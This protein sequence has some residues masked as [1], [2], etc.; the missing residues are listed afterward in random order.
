MRRRL[1]VMS[2][3]K[4]LWTRRPIRGVPSGCNAIVREVLRSPGSPIE[5]PVCALMEAS[6][7]CDFGRVR[8]YTDD[9]AAAASRALGAR[10]FTFGS[11]IIFGAGRYAPESR[12]GLW[13]LAHELAHVVQQAGEAPAVPLGLGDPDDPL[14]RAADQA[15]DLAAA[16]RA[17]PPGLARAVAPAGIIWCHDDEDCPGR[18]ISAA[19]RSIWLPANEAIEIAYKEDPRI[20]GHADAIL[21]GSQFENRDIQLPK[22]AP[23]KR[24]GNK[25][26]SRLRGISNQRRPDIIDFSGRVFYEI[27]S[28]NDPGRGTVQLESYYRLSEEIRR[29]YAD[30]DEPPWK[31]EYATWYPP[32]VLPFP[33]DPLNKIVCTKATDHNRWPGRILYD[34]RELD[35][36]EKRRRRLRNACDYSIADFDPEFVEL[37]PAIRAELPRKV[38]SYDPAHPE[39]VI[40]APREFYWARYRQRNQKW[41]DFIRVSPSYNMPGGREFQGMQ[42]INWTILTFVAAVSAGVYTVWIVAASPA[43]ASAISSAAG[44]GAAGAGAAGAGAAGAGAAAEAE[45]VSLAAYRALT[46]SPVARTL[47]KAAGVLMVVGAVQNAR[48]ASPSIRTSAIRVHPITDFQPVNGIPSAAGAPQP[49]DFVYSAKT[50]SRKAFAVGATVHF[51]SEPYVVIGQVV[52]GCGS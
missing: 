22:G 43:I 30:F 48:A 39:Y 3:E 6:F 19:D 23:N 20:R 49:S 24:Y 38:P 36:E 7:G 46:A 21:F 5:P 9:L 2:I 17:V 44:A 16:G 42:R 27:K 18:P 37:G 15:A 51:A 40:I 41:W 14:E 26:L 35:N 47:A 12:E 11:Q 1:L 28:V 4:T 8:L 45:I 33:G 34:V 10:A 52:V 32:H 31:V 25:L 50:G 29:A 13:L